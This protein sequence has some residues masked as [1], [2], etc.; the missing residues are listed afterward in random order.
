MRRIWRKFYS[1]IGIEK[2]MIE[3]KLK[4]APKTE[5]GLRAYIKK[6]F[7]MTLEQKLRD[8]LIEWIGK[9]INNH[10]ENEKVKSKS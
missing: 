10:R 7:N 5:K 2:E 4:L 6:Q 1:E 9:A 8:I 3:L